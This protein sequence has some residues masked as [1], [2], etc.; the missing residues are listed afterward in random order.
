M[1]EGQR[2]A[3]GKIQLGR[4]GLHPLRIGQRQLNG[5]PHIRCAQ[6][7]HHGTVSELHQAMDNALPVYQH[8]Y[9]LQR[10]PI[11]PHGLDHFQPLIHQGGAVHR[12]LRPHFPVGVTQSV[13]LGHILQVCGIHVKERAAGAGQQNLFHFPP[14]TATHEALEN[15]GMLGV[16]RNNF[17]P[18]FFRLGHHQLTGADQRLFVG[19][20]NALSCPNGSQGGLQADHAHNGGNDTIR[21]WN[22]R[23]CNQSILAP[24]DLGFFTGQRRLQF[25]RRLPGC[26]YRQL[27]VELAALLCHQLHIGSSGQ[28]CNLNLLEVF[29]DIQALPSNGTGTA[30]NAYTFHH[31]ISPPASVKS[32]PPP[33]EQP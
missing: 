31:F 7:C 16:H 27:R 11:Q 29:N 15:G 19:Q 28:R 2:R 4:G 1:A 22:G 3:L 30:Q 18:A 33:K 20:A 17:R 13:C 8:L 21:P 6:L 14:V 5:Q 24:G 25:L 9:L 23:R 32:V 10:N 12:N 26:H